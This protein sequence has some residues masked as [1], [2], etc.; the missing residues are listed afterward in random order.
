MQGGAAT[1][2][3]REG[4]KGERVEWGPPF[5]DDRFRHVILVSTKRASERGDYIPPADKRGLSNISAL[6]TS[7][8][9]GEFSTA[10]K[11]FMEALETE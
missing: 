10:N 7:L 1:G 9:D 3:G 4:G 5:R 2:G 8:Y 11:T 6:P